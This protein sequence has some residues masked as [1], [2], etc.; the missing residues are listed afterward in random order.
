M[1]NYES[2]FGRGRA[3][4]FARDCGLRGGG[5]RFG[6][7]ARSHSRARRPAFAGRGLGLR[8]RRDF[9]AP[10]VR[11]GGGA[12]HRVQ[13]DGR[14]VAFAPPD[15]TGCGAADAN[16]RAGGDASG[17]DSAGGFAPPF[18]VDGN[19]SRF[20]G[21]ERAGEVGL[22]FGGLARAGRD[23]DFGAASQPRP[24]GANACGLWGGGGG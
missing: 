20:S 22:A 4:H 6:R 11:D 17:R 8:Q 15:D 3:R 19:S 18:G 12:E 9:D 24:H 1:R 21:G 16:G 14:R 2:A 7:G 10:A 23:N 13:I 5:G